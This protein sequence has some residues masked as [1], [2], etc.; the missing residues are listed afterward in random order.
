MAAEVKVDLS[1]I[2]ALALSRRSK[3]KLNNDSCF[4]MGF[5]RVENDFCCA[6]RLT[7]ILFTLTKLS[8]KQ[9][10]KIQNKLK[11]AIL[12]HALSLQLQLVLALQQ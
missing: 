8:Y 12:V 4:E 7:E 3:S 9:R 1:V 2:V 5:A 10:A 11:E 6:G